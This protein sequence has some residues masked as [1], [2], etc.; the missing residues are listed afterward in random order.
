MG[1]LLAAYVLAISWSALAQ[2]QRPDKDTLVQ[3][4]AKSA[5]MTP[6]DV[7]RFLREVGPAIREELKGGNEVTL[8]GLG[9]FRVVQIAAHKDLRG[10]DAILVPAV[11]TVEFVA[12]SSLNDAANSANAQPAATVPAF[13]YI[14]LPGQTPTD[15]VTRTRAVPLR[16]K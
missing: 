9:S 4:I 11:N 12:D 6:E 5:K 16:T 15:K 7:D 14:P 8:P 1:A 13:Q 2:S 3:R 10:G